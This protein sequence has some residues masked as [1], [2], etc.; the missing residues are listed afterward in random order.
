MSPEELAALAAALIPRGN[1][2]VAFTY[3]EP[4]INYEFVRDTSILLHQ[5]GLK[6]VMVTNGTASDGV[7]EELKGLVDAMNIDLKGFTDRY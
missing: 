6:S 1:I 3:N 7:L 4:L 5:H 2:G